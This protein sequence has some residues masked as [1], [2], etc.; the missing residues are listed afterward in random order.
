[1]R[2]NVVALRFLYCAYSTWCAKR[3]LCGFVLEPIAKPSHTEASVLCEI[4]GTLRTIFMKVV[5]SLIQC[6]YVSQVLIG[7]VLVLTL[8]EL[9]IPPRFICIC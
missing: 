6:V 8:Q 9:Q 1:V 3:T 5:R 4:L 7:K 2:E